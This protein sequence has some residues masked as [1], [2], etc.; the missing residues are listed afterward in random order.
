MKKMV[1][2]FVCILLLAV[3]ACS[4]SANRNGTE[5]SASPSASSASPAASSASTAE[6]SDSPAPAEI[7][8]LT[9]WSG[10]PPP[11]GLEKSKAS[12]TKIGLALAEATGVSFTT[13][14]TV[15][16]AEA[17][18]NLRLASGDF[19]DIISTGLNFVWTGKLLQAK[20]IIP[21]DGYFGNPEKYPN[22]AQ[23]PQRVLDHYRY[24][25][26]HIY[27]FPSMWYEDENSIFGY[28]AKLGWY[29]LPQYLDAVQMKQEDL[30]TIEG[31]EKFLRAVKAANLKNEDGLPVIPLSGVLIQSS[32]AGAPSLWQTVA[33]TF[34]VSMAGMGF[35][36]QADGSFLHYRDD[37]RLKSAFQWL[38]KMKRED[39]LDQEILAQTNEQ[40][41]SKV[42]T[43]R[44]ALVADSADSF[45]TAVTAGKS[46][47]TELQYLHYP[48]VSGV[49]RPGTSLTFN[50]DGSGGIFV[51][52]NNKNPDAVAAYADWASAQGKSRLW[53][54][55]FGPLG[56]Y[57]DWDPDAGKPYF[58]ITDPEL[59][60]AWEKGDYK[61]MVAQGSSTLI[62]A[63][64]FDLDPNFYRK[65][66]EANLFWIFG[67]HK[68]NVNE[69]FT[70]RQMPY[71]SV[72]MPSDGFYNKNSQT[73]N[74]LDIEFFA[75]LIAARSDDH[76][77]TV[78]GQYADKLESQGKWSKVKEEWI[79]TYGALSAKQ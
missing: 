69:G 58:V 76:F 38:N 46:Q 15:G 71:H 74:S 26:G 44:V 28:W 52:A 66:N 22:L 67:M 70:Q 57:W 47:A 36:Q 49:D 33:S 24:E 60:D 4:R 68:F 23:I 5:S 11:A 2:L 53:E 34:G 41:L 54:Y 13:N 8:E 62:N 73:L 56:Q 39:L 51:T 61:S 63:M 1:L 65:S 79:A 3:T 9:A 77:E 32:S 43:S 17:A 35:A 16:D 20:A 27:Q 12:D 37:P 18:F 29:V 72:T 50:P 7:I 64:P 10:N 30:N 59:K 45:W 42:T 14:F 19:E 6:S 31:V 40:M 25:D 55:Y 48:K 21:L 78:W 75:K